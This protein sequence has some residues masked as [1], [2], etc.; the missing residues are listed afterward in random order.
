MVAAET[1]TE[2][3]TDTEKLEG[4]PLIPGMVIASESPYSVRDVLTNSVMNFSE[5]QTY[6]TKGL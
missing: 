1:G 2:R 3:Y 6:F 5:N 4:F